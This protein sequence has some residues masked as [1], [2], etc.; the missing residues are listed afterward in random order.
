MWRMSERPG[1][2][3]V[4]NF[5]SRGLFPTL[6]VVL[7]ETM[8]ASAQLPPAIQADRYLV[9]AERELGNGDPA[10]ALATLDLILELQ[11]DHGLEI[12]EVFW[13]KRA[14]V[15]YDAGLYQTAVESATRYLE[16]AGRDGE[17]YQA[18]LELY[19]EAELAQQQGADWGLTPGEAFSDALSSGGQGPEMIDP[20]FAGAEFATNNEARDDYNGT[21]GVLATVVESGSAAYENGLR[22]GDV[23]THINRQRVRSLEEARGILGNARSTVILQVARGNRGVLI[24][25]R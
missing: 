1:R 17:Q 13:F 8:P 22:T 3:N 12:P 24:L 21:E 10:A 7:I 18:A 20:E 6:L 19:D 25:M 9:Q 15:S 11:S 14:Q 4:L 2:V 5:L 16:I 23:I